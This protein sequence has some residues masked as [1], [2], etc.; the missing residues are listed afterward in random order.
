MAGSTKEFE[1]LFKLKASLG[2]NFNSTFK[3]AINTNNQLRDSLMSIPCNQRLTATQSSLP[4]LIRTKNGWRSLTQSMT[5]YSRNCSRQANPQKHCGRSLK[6][7]KTRYNRPLP[8]SK[9]RKTIKQ[10]CRR[11]ESSRSKYG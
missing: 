9:N 5:D 2:G 4:L 10:L 3:S 7:M 6:R 1:L 11:T 8:K